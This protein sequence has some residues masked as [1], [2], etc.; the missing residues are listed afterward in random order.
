MRTKAPRDL[1]ADDVRNAAKTSIPQAQGESLQDAS[2]PGASVALTHAERAIVCLVLL[3]HTNKEIARQLCKSDE[4]VK[5][6][7]SSLM[8]RLGVRN[9]TELAH[10]ISSSG[11][12]ALLLRES[13]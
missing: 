7:L 13:R 4:T 9:R 11:A 6:Q 3:G 1:L 5:R 10:W 2:I 12:A 8:R